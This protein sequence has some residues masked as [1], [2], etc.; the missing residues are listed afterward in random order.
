MPLSNCYVKQPRWR[1]TT[2]LRRSKY[3]TE[4]IQKRQLVKSVIQ[5]YGAFHTNCYSVNENLGC[6]EKGGYT[7]RNSGC[8]NTSYIETP[9]NKHHW[10]K[11]CLRSLTFLLCFSASD[12]TLDVELVDGDGARWSCVIRTTWNQI[13]AKLMHHLHC[14]GG[15][16]MHVSALNNSATATMTFSQPQIK[17]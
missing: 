16:K 13:N 3:E 10:W 7:G 11:K 1:N 12:M 6:W 8:P 5:T 9:Q 14:S 17:Q 2:K 4:Q 15:V